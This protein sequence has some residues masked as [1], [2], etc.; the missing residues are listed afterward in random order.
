VEAATSVV[1]WKLF[2]NILKPFSLIS[3]RKKKA[4]EDFLT[5]DG[6]LSGYEVQQAKQ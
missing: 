2:E 6:E 4:S 1:H 5:N 3:W